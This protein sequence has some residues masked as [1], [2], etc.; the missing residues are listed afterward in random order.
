MAYI[1]TLLAPCDLSHISGMIQYVLP[2]YWHCVT[3]L[4]YQW[5]DTDC[6]TTLLALSVLSHLSGMV[7]PILPR[8]WHPVTFPTLVA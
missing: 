6:I 7:W 8:N 3:F 1:T 5:H 4:T 2:H